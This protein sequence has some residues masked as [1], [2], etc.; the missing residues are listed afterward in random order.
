MNKWEEAIAALRAAVALTPDFPGARQTLGQALQFG[1]RP[2]EAADIFRDEMARRGENPSLRASLG[3]A[4]FDAGLSEQALGELARAMQL[5]PHDEKI[6]SAY[7]LMLQY[8]PNLDAAS[9]LRENLKWDERHARPLRAQRRPHSIDRDPDRRL[10]IGYTSADFREHSASRF[11]LPL[12]DHHDRGERGFHISC[13][14]DVP[15]ADHI[16]QHIRERVDHW[17]DT[18]SVSDEQL[19]QI[20][21]EDRIDILVD[22]TMHMARSR[23]LVY[24]REPAPVQMCWLAYP[25]TTGLSTMH[26]R[27]TDP[28]LDP[29]GF[30]DRYSEESIRLPHTFWCY[31]AMS[32]EPV[33]E[34]PAA[35]QGCI[36]FG[37]LNNFCKVNEPTVSLW[38]KVLREVSGSRMILLAPPGAP[39]ERVLEQLSRH[40]VQAQRVEFVAFQPR[41]QYLKT[42]HRIDICLDTLPANGHT[43]SLDAFWMGVPVVTRVGH[44]L[45]GRAGLCQLSNLNLAELAASTDDE[46]VRIAKELA[47]NRSRLSELRRALRDRMRASPLADGADGARFARDMESVYRQLWQ[48]RLTN[49]S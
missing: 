19:A 44:T 37:C 39:R 40:E 10:R 43:T 29:P 48:R 24:A 26:Y 35:T 20:V 32:E 9:I 3:N 6:H 12:I 38:G 5:A 49:R 17:R 7:L 34:L 42:Y 28:Y 4:L 27:L 45:V 13:Y 33:S 8:Q 22:L 14:S 46:F 30:D 25:G 15:H 21:R 16:T 23:L 1:W 2:D 11:F 18:I 36:T 47:E 41:D 31:D